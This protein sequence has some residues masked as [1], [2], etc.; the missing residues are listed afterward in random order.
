MGIAELLAMSPWVCGL[1]LPHVMQEDTRFQT[2]H[3]ANPVQLLQDLA[4]PQS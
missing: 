2:S 4:L 1:S 3:S